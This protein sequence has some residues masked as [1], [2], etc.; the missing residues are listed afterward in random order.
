MISSPVLTE[1]VRTLRSVPDP[2][3][4][5]A[6]SIRRL[7]VAESELRVSL[8]ELDDAPGLGERRR[9]IARRNASIREFICALQSL[10]THLLNEQA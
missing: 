1:L 8:E 3:G 6:T 4:G 2:A 10:E 9:S 7:R 5:L